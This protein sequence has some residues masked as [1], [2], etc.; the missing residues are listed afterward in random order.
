MKNVVFV[1]CVVCVAL[2]FVGCSK[3]EAP[4]N[5][6]NNNNNSNNTT[7]T[8]ASAT[9]DGSST[10]SIP[11]GASS[12][13]RGY[14]IQSENAVTCVFS[15]GVK[16]LSVNVFGGTTGSFPFLEDG[17]KEKRWAQIS[18][19]NSLSDMSAS[20][21]GEGSVTITKFGA[22]GEKIEGTF[23]GKFMTFKGEMKVVTNGTFSATR[24]A[25]ID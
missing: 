24:S 10:F 15:D 2:S 17:N 18:F 5:S 3:D 20:I 11:I 7:T 9:I 25:D 6:N 23:S 8:H 21:A 4:T 12:M 13:A 22:I 14:Y 1:L 19:G 16:S